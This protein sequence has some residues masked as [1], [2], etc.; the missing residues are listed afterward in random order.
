MT[1]RNGMTPQW[2][3]KLTSHDQAA[4]DGGAMVNEIQRAYNS[5]QQ[6]AAEY[7][8]HAGEEA[9]GTFQ[10]RRGPSERARDV[11]YCG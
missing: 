10:S 5:F 8:A 9:G 1:E 2:V 4:V 7:Q 11:N 3:Q 6:M